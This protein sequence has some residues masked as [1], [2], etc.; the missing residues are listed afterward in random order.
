[1]GQLDSININM[2][3]FSNMWSE[4]TTR[5]KSA[6]KQEEQDVSVFHLFMLRIEAYTFD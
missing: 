2:L 4:L 1:M 6:W 3:C 5:F